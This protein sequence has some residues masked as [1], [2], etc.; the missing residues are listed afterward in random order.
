MSKKESHT[1]RNGIIITVVGG[2]I[3]SF[4]PPFL[5]FI[6]KILSWLLHIIKRIVLYMNSEH[7]VYGWII[8][9]LSILSLISIFII[10][11][12]LKKHEPGFHELYTEDH[13]FGVDWFWKYIGNGIINLWCLCPD[14]RTELV[15][16]EFIPD[17]Y[18]Y[19]HDNKMPH[20]TF[21]CE[22]CGVSKA[23]MNG[24]KNHALSTAEREILR[25][26]RTEEWKK[27]KVANQALNSDG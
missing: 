4:W 23:K 20:T 26:I 6:K 17:P 21:I 2:I 1:I 11:S 8:A 3:L 22:K 9:T 12:K 27:Q 16:S 24:S 18:N 19:L 14:C 7:L 10:I 5:S 25:K 13:L 15:F